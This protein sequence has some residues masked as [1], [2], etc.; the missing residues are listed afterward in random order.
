MIEVTDDMKV[1]VPFKRVIWY[2]DCRSDG[3][4]ILLVV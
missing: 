2:H 3:G 4:R 1:Y